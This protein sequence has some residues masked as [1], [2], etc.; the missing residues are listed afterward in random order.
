MNFK[1]QILVVVVVVVAMIFLVNMIRER[2]MELKYSLLWFVMG[3]GVAIFGCFPQLTS[4]LA[5]FLG[6]SQPINLLFFVGFCFSLLI[7]FSLTV[8]I[9]RLSVKVKRLV[10][11]VALLNKKLEIKEGDKSD[12]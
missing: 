12:E 10:Q 6:I 4:C 9:S 7:I 1:T 3:I 11:E 2:K 8:A 5:A